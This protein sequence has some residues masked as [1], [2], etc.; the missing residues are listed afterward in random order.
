MLTT[1]E[2]SKKNKKLLQKV[3]KDSRNM[4]STAL[5]EALTNNLNQNKGGFKYD[6]K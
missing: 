4:D 1:I 2:N 5:F 3:L 6:K